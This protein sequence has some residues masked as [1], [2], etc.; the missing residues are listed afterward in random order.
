MS[1]HKFHRQWLDILRFAQVGE[2]QNRVLLAQFFWNQFGKNPVGFETFLTEF[3]R[4]LNKERSP[5]KKRE[6]AK[7]YLSFLSSLCERFG[8]FANKIALDDHC[9]DIVDPI[10]SRKIKLFL[11]KYEKKSEGTI[12]KIKEALEKVLLENGYNAVIKGR[13]KSTYS[14]HRKLLKK[15]SSEMLKLRDIFAFRIIVP[16]NNIEECFEVAMLLHDR[17]FPVPE[18][19]K[20]YITIPKINGYQSIHTG[21]TK[22]VPELDLVVEIQIRSEEMDRFAEKGLAAHW[23]YAQHKKA[24]WI[25]SKGEHLMN[26]LSQKAPYATDEVYFFSYRGDLFKLPKGATLLDFAYCLHTDIGNTLKGARINGKDASIEHVIQ[27]GDRIELIKAAEPQVNSEW[28][29]HIFTPYAR[30][31]IKEAIK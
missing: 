18:A 7:R 16:G 8:S 23:Q 20:D 31:K 17:F 26:Y 14:I 4:A 15:K 30:R 11:K 3:G 27:T 1:I 21:L 29:N 9:F 5:H 10:H 12:Q 6:L 28:L 19:F 22:V 25:S 13:Y 24:R 2:A